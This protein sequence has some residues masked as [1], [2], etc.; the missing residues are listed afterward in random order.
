MCDSA[1][2]LREPTLLTHHLAR[3]CVAG[4]L[5]V[6][7]CVCVYVADALVV[8]CTWDTTSVTGMTKGG[9]AS[10]DEMCFIFLFYYPR[11]LTNT[12]TDIDSCN[13]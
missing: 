12:G 6:C 8:T 2:A 7:M 10:T 3:A 1:R 13:A 5:G 9:E 11:L 4:W